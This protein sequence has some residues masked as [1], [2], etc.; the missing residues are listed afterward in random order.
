MILMYLF[1]YYK[2]SANIK[3]PREITLKAT[4]R[5]GRLIEYESSVNNHFIQILFTWNNIINNDKYLS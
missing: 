2:S 4:I 5:R 3:S 1:Y